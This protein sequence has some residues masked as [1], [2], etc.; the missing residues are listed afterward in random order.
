MQITGHFLCPNQ[1]SRAEQALARQ[2]SGARCRLEEG[3]LADDGVVGPVN[4]EE[5]GARAVADCGPPGRQPVRLVVEA[6]P[7]LAEEIGAI[8]RS[9]GATQ[10]VH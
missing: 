3:G 5:Q 1:A 10:V 6:G 4:C 8:L 2:L 7:E 9:H